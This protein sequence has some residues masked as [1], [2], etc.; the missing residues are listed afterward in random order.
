MTLRS[1]ILRSKI[2]NTELLSLYGEEPLSSG[3]TVAVVWK[4]L[5]DKCSQRFCSGSAGFGELRQIMLRVHKECC[6]TDERWN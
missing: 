4:E 1:P 5:A 2:D 3:Q 6:P